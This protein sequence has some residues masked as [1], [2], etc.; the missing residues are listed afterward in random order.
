[1]KPAALVSMLLVLVASAVKAQLTLLPQIGF[2]RSKTSVQYNELSSFSPL[3]GKGNLK[4]NLRLDYRFPKG[5]GPYA[6]FGTAPAVVEF[7]FAD[8][9]NAMSNFKAAA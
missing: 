8:P 3:G 7:S 5:H 6:S 2:D 9:S 1:M 4:A